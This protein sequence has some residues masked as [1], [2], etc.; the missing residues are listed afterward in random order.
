M[1]AK[2]KTI[3]VLNL[4]CDSAVITIKQQHCTQIRIYYRPICLL[5]ISDPF[6]LNI[7]HIGGDLAAVSLRRRGGPC[8]DSWEPAVNMSI[9]CIMGKSHWSDLTC[10]S[11]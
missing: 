5:L 10:S 2:D 6:L 7:E 3:K 4:T 11:F 9:Q 8:G 1:H